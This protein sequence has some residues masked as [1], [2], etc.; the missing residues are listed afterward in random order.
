MQGNA[1]ELHEDYASVRIMCYLGI[2]MRSQLPQ[3]TRKC[4]LPGCVELQIGKY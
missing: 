4:M 2:V 1:A 3:W